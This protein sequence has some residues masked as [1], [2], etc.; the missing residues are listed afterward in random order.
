VTPAQGLL[1]LVP[2]DS[3][4]EIEAMVANRDIGFVRPGQEVAIKV[5]TFNFTRYGLLH[6]RM[7]SISS[8]AIAHDSSA[9]KP[10]S[11]PSDGE[12]QG[13]S[14]AARI[15]LDRSDMQVDDRLVSLAAGMTVIVEIET[16]SR[17]LISYLLSPI[18]KYGHQSF[19]ER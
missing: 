6:G 8:D 14:Y 5:D 18:A 13:P 10:A 17:R 7:L 15:S 1:V 4:L 12:G 16:G 9:D 11:R 19:R 2:A 3:H